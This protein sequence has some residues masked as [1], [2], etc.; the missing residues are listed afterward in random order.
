MQPLPTSAYKYF[1]EIDPAELVVEE[2]PRY[3]IERLLEYGDVPE[4]L[5]LFQ[6]F[7]RD[8]IIATLKSSRNLSRRRASAWANYFEIPQV[9]IKCLRKPSPK[10]HAVTWTF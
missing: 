6:N 4:L 10:Q 7:T 5:W 1:W 8:K 9:E 3:V 2:H